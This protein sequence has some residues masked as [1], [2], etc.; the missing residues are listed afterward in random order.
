MSNGEVRKHPYSAMK[1]P[2]RN[3]LSPQ[4]MPNYSVVL[5]TLTVFPSSKDILRYHENLPVCG[6]K[7]CSI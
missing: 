6:Q 5:K 4:L 2:V 7:R 1:A 3:F